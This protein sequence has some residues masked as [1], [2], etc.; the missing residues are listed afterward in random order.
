M[1]NE[2]KIQVMG[3]LMGHYFDNYSLPSFFLYL[4]KNYYSYFYCQMENFTQKFYWT[5]LKVSSL[6]P[7]NFFGIRI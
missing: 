2:I 5:Y 4:K 3:N 1:K 7:N 6:W